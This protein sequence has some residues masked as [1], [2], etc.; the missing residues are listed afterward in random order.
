MKNEGSNKLQL[1]FEKAK[2][3]DRFAFGVFADPAAA[4]EKAGIHLNRTEIKI[5]ADGVAEARKYFAER[6]YLASVLGTSVLGKRSGNSFCI[7]CSY[8]PPPPPTK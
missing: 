6:L 5:L 2:S 1:V 4:C 8:N 7:A 3:D